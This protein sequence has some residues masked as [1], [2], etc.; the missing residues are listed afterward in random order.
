MSRQKWVVIIGIFVF[1]A[2]T[3]QALKTRGDNIGACGR[4]SE[5]RVSEL[6]E[7]NMLVD[8][9]YDRISAASSPPEAASNRR[10]MWRYA[11]VRL[12][13]VDSQRDVALVDDWHPRPDV[14][15]ALDPPPDETVIADCEK[16]YPL[17]WPLSWG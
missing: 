6:H 12:E 13:L 1:V 15:P 5:V 16:A 10:A 7:R 17:P 8:V 3:T 4:N 14:S 11:T 9:N 2:V